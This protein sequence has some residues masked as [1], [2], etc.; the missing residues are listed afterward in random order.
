M[1]TMNLIS[2]LLFLLLVD[3]SLGRINRERRTNEVRQQCAD[4]KGFKIISKRGKTRNCSWLTKRKLSN[5]VK[6]CNRWQKESQMR[7]RDACRSTCNNCSE[8]PNDP[9]LPKPNL[10]MILTDEHNIRTLSTYRNYMVGKYG[11]DKVDVW[12]PA[13]KMS[14][15]N[16]DSLA[17][18]GAMLT[19]FYTVAPVCT[20]S[21]LVNLNLC[22]P[23]VLLICCIL[24]CHH[25]S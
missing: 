10:V 5:R 17:N 2:L 15:P 1:A 14:T 19:N 20:P 13:A 8:V 23:S 11:E 22:C 21:R 4:E 16:I 25:S 6:L 3:S 18:E 9:G 7:I 12:G 24:L